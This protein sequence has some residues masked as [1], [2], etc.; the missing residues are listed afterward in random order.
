MFC[1]VEY[2]VPETNKVAERRVV[3]TNHLISTLTVKNQYDARVTGGKTGA[4]STT[5]RSLICTAEYDGKTYLSVVM[6]NTSADTIAMAKTA[7][8]PMI[9]QFTND[10][11]SGI[12][13]LGVNG[14]ICPSASRTSCA[15]IRSL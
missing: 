5:D 2:T 9:S 6:I 14:R 13:A 8:P 15:A 1:A 11:S 3:T 10:A 4:L 7:I 12:S